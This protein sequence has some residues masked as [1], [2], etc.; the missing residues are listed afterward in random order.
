M[1]GNN[2]AGGIFLLKNNHGFKDRSE[3]DVTSGGQPIPI[4]GGVSV[5]KDDS[6]K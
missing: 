1:S 6:N 4:L 5:H 2:A 3:T